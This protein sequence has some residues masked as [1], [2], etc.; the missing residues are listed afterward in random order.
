MERHNR[1]IESQ[2]K[3]GANAA[4]AANA[5]SAGNSSGAGVGNGIVSD[6]TSRIPVAGPF[7]VPILKKLGLGLADI[8]TITKSG[9]VRCNGISVKTVGE[10]LFIETEKGLNLRTQNAGN[11][12][13][14]RAKAPMM[15]S[16][17]EFVEAIFRDIQPQSNFDI[18]RICK[19]TQNM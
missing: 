15:T 2:L 5:A 13:F 17:E 3:S 11:G 8:N 18:I 1:D 14:F 19:K 4:N 16:F 12:L 7:I 6:A 9:C 10:G